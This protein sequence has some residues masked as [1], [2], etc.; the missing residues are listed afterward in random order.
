MTNQDAIEKPQVGMETAPE[1][2]PEV[3]KETIP[4]PEKPEAPLKPEEKPKEKAPPPPK[5]APPKAVPKKKELPEKSEQLMKI[6][7]ILAEDLEDYYFSM[8]D[9]LK[10]TFKHKGEET[11]RTA[12]QMIKKAKVNLRKLVKLIFEWLKIIPGINKFFIEQEA[13]IKAD[14]I[15]KEVK[16]TTQKWSD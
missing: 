6:E 10:L 3:E 16:D 9:D 7:K 12:E 14:K 8:S 11:A 2:A 5:A 1:A 13:K 4:S 15:L